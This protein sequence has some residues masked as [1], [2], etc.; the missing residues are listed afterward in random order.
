MKKDKFYL[1]L[2]YIVYSVLCVLT[3]VFIVMLC[4]SNYEVAEPLV[5]VIII[6]ALWYYAAY[7]EYKKD[8]E[9]YK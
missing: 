8:K 5:W 1:Y 6:V 9:K 3:I 2:K 7:T 4:F